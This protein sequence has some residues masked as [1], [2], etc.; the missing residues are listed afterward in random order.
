MAEIAFSNSPAADPS[1]RL[2]N[3]IISPTRTLHGSVESAGGQTT[4]T[5]SVVD[6]ATG[7]SHGTV[8]STGADDRFFEI[9][10]DVA[11]KLE[12]LLCEPSGRWV[13]TASEDAV[14]TSPQGTLT[15][16]AEATVTWS[17]AAFDPTG[18]ILQPT[19]SVTISAT[20]SAGPCSISLPATTLPIGPNEGMLQFVGDQYVIVG[21]GAGGGALLDYVYSCPEGSTIRPGDVKPWLQAPPQPR[22]PEGEPLQGT[23]SSEGITYTWRFDAEVQ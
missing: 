9:E 7:Q 2:Q 4:I 11:K 18:S 19:G 16:H 12:R 15:R 6:V 5:V 1:T 20:G 17:P 14:L 23:H 3:R 13:G 21:A 10:A 8:S 22:P